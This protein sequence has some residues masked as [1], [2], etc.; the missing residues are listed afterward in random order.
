MYQKIDLNM[1]ILYRQILHTYQSM[2]LSHVDF[3]KRIDKSTHFNLL[4]EYLMLYIWSY[5]GS[6]H[7][8]KWSSKQKKYII[9]SGV[10]EHFKKCPVNDPC[11]CGSE[12][13]YKKCCIN[14][15]KPQSNEGL[16]MMRGCSYYR[17]TNIPR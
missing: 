17:H 7:N 4:P 2:Q 10:R 13:K 12:I 11:W 1:Y 9:I 16:Q 6:R 3:Q 5:V 8:L 15:Y 14:Y